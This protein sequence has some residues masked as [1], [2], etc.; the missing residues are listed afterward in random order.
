MADGTA[1][2]ASVSADLN[3]AFG[4]SRRR[5]PKFPFRALALSGHQINGVLPAQLVTFCHACSAAGGSLSMC[6]KNIA[7]IQIC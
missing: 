6:F 5:S 2:A 7:R 4:T 3:N 1:K